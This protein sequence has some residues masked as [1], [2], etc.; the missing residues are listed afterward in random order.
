MYGLGAKAH[1]A[2]TDPT[3]QPTPKL[4]NREVLS[5]HQFIVVENAVLRGA[6]VTYPCP[7]DLGGGNWD[8]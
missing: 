4:A 1:S 7:Q 6:W 8:Q 3:L 5:S 2:L